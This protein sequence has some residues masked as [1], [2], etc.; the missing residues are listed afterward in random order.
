MRER[1]PVNATVTV[2][3]A[4]GALVVLVAAIALRVADRLGPAE[5]AALPRARPGAGRGRLRRAASTNYSLT[6]RPSA[7]RR[8]WSSSRRAGSPRGGPTCAGRSGPGSGWPRSASSSASS[9]R[10]RPRYACSALPGARRCSSRRCVSSTDAAAVFATLRRLPLPRRMAGGAGGRVRAQRRAG[11]PAGRRARRP[12]DR[13]A[14]AAL[15]ARPCSRWSRAGRGRRRRPR[16]RAGR[17]RSCCGAPPC[18]CPASIRWPPS[19]CACWR[20]RRPRCCTP[21]AS[22][23]STS[24]GWCWATRALPH[25]AASLGFAEGMASLA[26]IGLFVLLGLLVTPSRLP[27]ALGP[28][29]VIG[30]VLLLRGP[31]AVGA[32]EP[33][34]GS[35]CRWP[36]QAFISWAGLRG[37]RPDRAG[38]FPADRA[39]CPG[40]TCIFDTVFVLVVVFTAGPGRVAAVAGPAAAG[41]PRR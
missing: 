40:A 33:A 22:S 13:R 26:Q 41:S 24:A 38:D 8:W 4:L 31:A 17:A 3:L 15:V 7:S 27:D 1:R 6:R 36:Q 28:A 34:P 20:S 37:R 18:P 19:R 29:L 35:A 5:P 2:A 16:A 32:G 11:D 23:P 14:P 25:R 21:R 30:G 12:P 10:P 9:S 39:A